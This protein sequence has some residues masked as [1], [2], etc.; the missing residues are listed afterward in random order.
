MKRDKTNK[1]DV[2]SDAFWLY[3][4]GLLTLVVK[5]QID[6]ARARR[7][8]VQNIEVTTQAKRE[9]VSELK[10]ATLEV[11]EQAKGVAVIANRAVNEAKE[12]AQATKEAAETLVGTTEHIKGSLNGHLDDK[13]AAISDHN[14]RIAALEMSLA[15]MQSDVKQILEIVR[16]T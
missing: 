10:S 15:T 9:V 6:R 5:D 4:F 13:F 8:E 16:P 7:A 11:K 12:T 2:M 1:E 14:N 3:F